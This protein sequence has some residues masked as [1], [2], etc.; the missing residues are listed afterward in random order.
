M[1]DYSPTGCTFRNG[2]RCGIDGATCGFAIV[3]EWGGAPLGWE[4]SHSPEGASE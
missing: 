4:C 2:K 1:P 3:N